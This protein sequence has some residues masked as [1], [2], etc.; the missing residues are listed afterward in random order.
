[1]PSVVF[2][3]GVNVGSNNRFQPSALAKQ[4]ASYE[5]INVGAAGTFVVKGEVSATRL[6]SEI[7]RQLAF[8][9]E[10][11]ICPADEI[12]SLAKSEPFKHEKLSRETRAF[13]TVVARKAN[14]PPKLP[15]YAPNKADWEVKVLRISGSAALSLW[16]PMGNRIL[17]PNEVV[18]KALGAPSTTRSWNTIEKVLKILG[19]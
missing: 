19:Q 15:L 8:K 3:R 6:R 12:I 11:L 10:V 14:D 5:V 2:L 17:Y 9:P 1:M 7:L 18:E 13:L 4:L 16:R